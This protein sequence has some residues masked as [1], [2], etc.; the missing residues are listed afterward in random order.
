MRSVKTVHKLFCCNTLF[1]FLQ[2]A[3]YQ[4]FHRLVNIRPS[5][6]NSC[7]TQDSH[8]NSAAEIFKEAVFQLTSNPGPLDE[9]LKRVVDI[10]NTDQELAVIHNIIETLFEQVGD[11]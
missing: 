9:L 10:L 5:H 4:D 2:E 3:L 6:L 11:H 7:T 8:R 1:F